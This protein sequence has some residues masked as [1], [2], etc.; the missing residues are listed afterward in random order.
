[1][2]KK[3]LEQKLQK[4]NEAIQLT[5]AIKENE[6]QQRLQKEEKLHRLKSELEKKKNDLK[7]L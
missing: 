7:M 6:E 2:A 5:N 3:E 4:E 1:M